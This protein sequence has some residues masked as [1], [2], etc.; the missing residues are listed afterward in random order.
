MEE[1]PA[2]GTVLLKKSRKFE[3]VPE[4]GNVSGKASV[5]EIQETLLVKNLGEGIHVFDGSGYMNGTAF[6]E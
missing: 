1:C 5:V 4:E 6:L 3:R 2:E